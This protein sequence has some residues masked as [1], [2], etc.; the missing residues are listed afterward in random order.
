MGFMKEKVGTK[1]ANYIGAFTEYDKNNNS[2]FWRQ[3]MRIRVKVDVRLP[4]KKDAKVMD[5]EG[6]WCTVKFKYEKLGTFCFVCGVIGHAENKCEIRFSMEEDDG[7]REWSAEIRV[8]SRR[9]GGRIVSRWL[10]E[11]RGGSVEQSG[12]GAAGQPRVPGES[13]RR[14]ATFDDVAAGVILTNQNDSLHSGTNQAAII[15]RQDSS[16]AL[17]SNQT[18]PTVPINPNINSPFQILTGQPTHI[19]KTNFPAFISSNSTFQNVSQLLLPTD[20][21]ITPFSNINTPINLTQQ[22]MESHKHN[23]FTQHLLTFTSQSQKR[24]PHHSTHKT[25]HQPRVTTKSATTNRPNTAPVPDPTHAR[26]RPEKKS[27]TII[28]K[29]LTQHLSETMPEPDNLEDMESQ[30]EKK[31]RREED[32]SANNDNSQNYEHFLTTGPGSQ[33][34]RDQ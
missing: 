4:L 33:A 19:P 27:K 7:T 18:P 31:R 28:H 14:G 17:N 11:E 10:K 3:Y 21:I 16:L 6:K 23:S 20:T 24:D 25:T 32:I 1:L 8:D 15:T 22:K 12:G 34:C 2:S 26:T 9:Q 5:K 13:S 30:T 29:N